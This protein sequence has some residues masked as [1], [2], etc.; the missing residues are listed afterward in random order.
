MNETLP[1]VV[2]I[3][4]IVA[5][6]AYLVYKK[7]K[8]LYVTDPAKVDWSR[9]PSGSVPLSDNKQQTTPKGA[10][11]FSKDGVSSTVLN[12]IDAG[13]DGAFADARISGYTQ[14]LEHSSYEIWIPRYAC[15]PSPEG[16]VPSFLI[17]SDSYDGTVYDYY[18]PKGAGVKDGVGVIYAAEMVTNLGFGGRGAMVC[19]SDES[20]VENATRYGAEHIIIANNDPE[21]YDISWFHGTGGH[22]L[23]PKPQTP[24]LTA[25]V[26][27]KPDTDIGE[28]FLKAE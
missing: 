4:G 12:L 2:L 19:C 11:V 28:V 9:M 8:N 23:L 16:R 22:P 21:Y 3:V 20:V 10:V 7:Y 27:D 18:N 13:L 15:I 24:T 5:L 26:T 14:K 25:D 17:R 6:I 1:I